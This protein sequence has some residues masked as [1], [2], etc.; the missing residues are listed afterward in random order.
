MS[1]KIRVGV[2]FGGRSA[3]H[4]VS[5]QSAKNV[6]ESLDKQKYEVVLIGIAKNGQW[7][8][9]GSSTYLRNE[10]DPMKIAI[11]EEG[12]TVM[13]LT[14]G[15][16]KSRVIDVVF[17]VLH[18]TYG[19]DGT[20]QGLLEIMDLP[21]V[22]AGVL[23][24]AVGMDKD[25]AKRLLRDAGIPVARFIVMHS[26]DEFRSDEIESEIRYPMF[27][28]PARAG[29]SVGVSKVR[30]AVELESAIRIALRYDSKVLIEEYIPGSEIECSVLGNDNPVVSLPGMVV[31]KHE[32][33]SYEAKYIDEN[34]AQLMIPAKLEEDVIKKI[35]TTALATYRVLCL[36]GMAR[37]DM[38][39]TSDNSLVV[40]EV[41]TIPGFT[42]ISM[43]PK[44]WEASGVSYSEL[45]DRLINLA[46]ERHAKR[47]LLLTTHEAQK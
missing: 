17:P 19:E 34:G 43:Y 42:N 35:Q 4:E 1:H 22:G 21:Y 41:N 11:A 7:L 14:P 27:V 38:F 32:F 37:V 40:N 20:M 2:L 31:P 44:L 45:L 33:Y 29:S 25:V 13:S 16:S 18:G 8:M 28:K 3:E 46:L 30:T 10:T 26:T 5:L 6:I 47:K 36:E 9:H 15:E 23:G 24:S 12:T 39:L